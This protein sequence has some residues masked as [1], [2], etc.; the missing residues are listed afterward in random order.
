MGIGPPTYILLPITMWYQKRILV[1]G[2]WESD[3]LFCFW[4]RALYCA[5]HFCWTPGWRKLHQRD[6][7]GI[8]ITTNWKVYLL[9]R[10]TEEWIPLPIPWEVNHRSEALAGEILSP[11]GDAGLELTQPE[12]GC[13]T[14]CDILQL[15]LPLLKRG[16]KW[17]ACDAS[18][19][20]AAGF[21]PLA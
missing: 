8:A 11:A 16:W 5:T 7:G 19:P 4:I 2:I 15:F 14:S 21:T 9:K 1:R 10:Q 17:P 13:Q 6:K 3:M 20:Q 12:H 18:G